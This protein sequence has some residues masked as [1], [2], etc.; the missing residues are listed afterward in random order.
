MNLDAALQTFIAESQ[1]LLT[2]ME[3]ALLECERG[4][5]T[6]EVLNAIFRAAHTIKGSAGLFGLQVVV[7]F[8]HGVETVLD[9]VRVGRRA[10]DNAL[11]ALLV[12]CRDH[13]VQL[14]SAIARGGTGADPQ[15]DATGMALTERLVGCPAKAAVPAKLAD[16]SAAD[17]EAESTLVE[18]LICSDC[19]HIS[20]R[21]GNGV[22]RDGMDPLSF[23]RYL[24]TFGDLCGVI[25][26]DDALPP[27]DQFDPES[28]YLGFEIRFKTEADKAQIEGAFDFVREACKLTIL[29]PRARIDEFVQLLQQAPDPFARLGELLVGIGTLTT[30]ELERALRTQEQ[31]A[32]HLAPPPLGEI[33][34]RQGAVQPAVIEAA[35]A[36][37]H[38]QPERE[39]QSIRVDAHKLERLIDLIGELIIAGAST[40]LIAQRAALGELSE[41]T[42]RLSRLVEEVRDCALQLRMVQIGA[43]FSRFQRVVRDVSRELGKDIRLQINGAETELDKTL[44]EGINDPLTHLVRNAIDHGIETAAVRLQQGKPAQGFVKLDAYHDSGSVVIEVSDDGCGLDRERILARAHER[45]W[46]AAD[47]VL[48]DRETYALIFEPGFS[49]ARE[50]T[51]LSGRGVGMDVVL[52]NVTALRGTVEVDSLPGLGATVRIRLPLTLAIIDGFLVRVGRSRFVIPLDLVDECIELP[53]LQGAHRFVDL[54]GTP[55]PF[56]RLRELFA[57]REAAAR[58]ESIVV[59]RTKGQ[60]AGFVVDELLGEHQTVIKSLPPVMSGMRGLS[61]STI[62]A[63]GAIALIVDAAAL[64]EQ[65]MTMPLPR[66]PAQPPFPPQAHLA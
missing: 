2:E 6:P 21:F 52:R 32:K 25:V 15:L 59:V 56:V 24:S 62:L 60:R 26:I 3:A 53:P 46:I 17:A 36:R 50:V 51:N 18:E 54:R 7:D 27:A 47:A 45:G 64:L 29:P 34:I 13:M 42:S 49:T 66:P 38:G 40:N 35:V 23:L 11:L 33:L 55:L 37:Q 12:E 20:V 43:T 41:S 14:I 4:A 19:W 44:V 1:E 31:V 28:C 57:V 16:Q 63:D 22:L 39:P 48:S 5:A 10:L 65:C 58:R 8:T 9:D 61:G 30:P